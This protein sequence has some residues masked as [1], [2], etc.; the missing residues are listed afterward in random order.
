MDPL[1]RKTLLENLVFAAILAS[2]GLGA[3]IAQ[4]L[5]S[6]LARDGDA[7]RFAFEAKIQAVDPVEARPSFPANDRTALFRW[8]DSR[9]RH[10]GKTFAIGSNGISAMIALVMSSEGKPEEFRPLGSANPRLLL[11]DA[12]LKGMLAFPPLGAGSVSDRSRMAALVE[13]RRFAQ[14]LVEDVD[15]MAR[16]ILSVEG[17]AAAR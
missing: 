11:D 16:I 13:Q 6:S 4:G 1:A 2:L 5:V 7:R 17:K 3:I 10:Y 12:S 9:G 14:I 8:E 15:A